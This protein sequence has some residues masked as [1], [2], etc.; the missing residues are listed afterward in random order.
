M[1]TETGQV[2]IP[3]NP[4]HIHW[5]NLKYKDHK[6]VSQSLQVRTLLQT[7]NDFPIENM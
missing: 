1:P 6:L 5:Q 4:T 2:Y 3:Q 7:V